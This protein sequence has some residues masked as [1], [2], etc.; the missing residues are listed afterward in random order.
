MKR[1][2]LEAIGVAAAIL[3]VTALPEFVS[4]PVGGQAGTSG[5][6][7]A[8]R[9]GPAPVTPWGEPDLQGIWNDV[10]QT[11][12]QRSP[13][14]GTRELFT[15]EERQ[16]QDRRR[17]AAP[18]LDSRVAPRGSEQDVSGAYNAVFTSVRPSSPRTSL[19]VDPENGRIPPRT[20]QAIERT[21]AIRAFQL[22]L[23]QPT[24][25]CRNAL[26][27]CA[28][29]KYGPPSPRRLE[30]P[31]YYLATS[32]AAGGSINR[33][34]GPEDRSLAERCM[35]GGLPDFGGYRRIVQSRG[36]VAI[37]YDTGQGQGWQ[38]MIQVTSNPHV[39][40]AVRQWQG[41]SRGRWEGNTLVVDVTNFTAKT[42][43]QGSRENLHLV[44]RWTRL[45]ADTLEYVVTLEDP[46]TWTGPWTVKQ[47]LTRQ[48][49]RAN[50]IYYEPRCHEG[51][52]GMVGL[53]VGTRVDEKAFAEGRGPD[54][55]TKCTAG[56]GTGLEAAEGAP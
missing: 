27:G 44:E 14:L 8:A 35:S 30:V 22:A 25:A 32:A 7:P 13:Q 41:D 29:G 50:R 12:L 19:I 1:R 39:P 3:V 55:A 40:P 47:A 43:Y 4:A 51:N 16:A 5:A 36:S 24:D 21:N 48:P 42:D 46:T 33:A 37:F 2:L 49:E 38:R 18:T 11:P 10:Y 45:D 17:S 15:D 28:G 23:L 9:P 26:P 53:L 52:Y 54:P 20:P 34:D 6:T 56:C 31:P